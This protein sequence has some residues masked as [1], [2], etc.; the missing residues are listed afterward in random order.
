MSKRIFDLF[1]SLIGITIL[2]PLFLM[3]A[4]SIKL[5]SPGPVFFRQVRVGRFGCEFKIYKF[6]TMIIEAEKMGKQITIDNDQR[7]TRIGRFL[8]KYK[9]DELPQLLNV[10]KGEM[11][12]VGPRP[13]VPKYVYMY[14]HEQRRVL[15]V[16]PGITD[17]A[18][19]KFRNENQ[20]LKH[21]HNPEDFYIHE[22]MPQ[23]LK[24]NIEYIEQMG[25]SFDLLIICKTL[26]Q[27]IAT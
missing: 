14:T 10:I 6:R 16:L 5:D 3:I 2:L 27:V 1:F 21:N 17:L 15:E 26:L 25:L 4:I 13:E 24:L 22:I 20:L 9:L 7:I 19:I 8:R 23:K 11:S 12:L 18:S